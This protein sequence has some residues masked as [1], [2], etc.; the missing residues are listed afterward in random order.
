MRRDMEYSL[1]KVLVE[2]G[3]PG[4]IVLGR[5]VLSCQGFRYSPAPFP[6]GEALLGSRPVEFQ[7]IR[8]LSSRHNNLIALADG[9]K[10]INLHKIR[11]ESDNKRCA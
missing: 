5:P 6:T 11:A 8:L 4:N 3:R 10:N 7:R 2:K 1:L 9:R